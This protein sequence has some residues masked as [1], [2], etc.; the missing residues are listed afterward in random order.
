MHEI[1]SLEEPRSIFKVGDRVF[2]KTLN[3][4]EVFEVTSIIYET[5]LGFLLSLLNKE[6]NI[7]KSRVSEKECYLIPS[8]DDIR[9]ELEVSD[10]NKHIDNIRIMFRTCKVDR[11]LNNL[12]ALKELIDSLDEFWSKL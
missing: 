10:F 3:G 1:F 9:L 7:L 5:S 6:Q 8:E 4:Y 2:N 12:N 11:N